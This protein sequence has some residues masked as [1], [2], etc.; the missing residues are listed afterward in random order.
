MNYVNLNRNSRH[1]LLICKVIAYHSLRST[2]LDHVLYCFFTAPN[3]LSHPSLFFL[4]FLLFSCLNCLFLKAHRQNYR[5]IKITFLGEAR[6]FQKEI[7]SLAPIVTLLINTLNKH[8]I[9]RSTFFRTRLWMDMSMEH[10]YV[11]L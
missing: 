9:T 2:L 8:I 11:S 1:I 3:F 10:R 6:I 5:L 4:D 7:T